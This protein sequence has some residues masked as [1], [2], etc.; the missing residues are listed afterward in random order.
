MKL[1]DVLRPA[2]SIVGS[3]AVRADRTALLAAIAAVPAAE[4]AVT[5]ARAT[6]DRLQAVIGKAD[7]AARTAADAQRAAEGARQRW[8]SRGCE[9]SAAL[10]HHRLAEV[11]AEATRAAEHAAADVRAVSQE[12]RHAEQTIQEA[13][14]QVRDCEHGI[15]SQIGAI[16]ASEEAALFEQYAQA[17][18]E[19]RTLR[20]KLMALHS[21]L[22]PWTPHGNAIAPTREGA[23]MVDAALQRGVIANWDQERDSTR[24]REWEESPRRDE[25]MILFEQCVARWRDRAAALRANP[26]AE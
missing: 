25:P 9:Y 8:I 13:Q 6:L 23:A 22:D 11:A 12:L 18:D 15:A 26:D 20:V 24:V 2:L 10:E 7:D 3:S 14:S 21:I 17:T 1:L 16:I 5:D 19:V 4:R